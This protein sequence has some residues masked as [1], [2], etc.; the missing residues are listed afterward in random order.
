MDLKN[1]FE[2]IDLKNTEEIF[3][4]LIQNKNFK[5]ER[6]ISN[7]QASP[8]DF[9]YQQNLNEWVLLVSGSACLYF[10]DND[11]K[12]I[13]KP[14]DHCNIPAQKKHRVEWTDA[15]QPTIWLALFY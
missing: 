6:I 14:G 9:Y 3:E 12:L 8:E 10:P 11:E 15:H 2:D 4:I 5:L 1:I 13:L 7:G